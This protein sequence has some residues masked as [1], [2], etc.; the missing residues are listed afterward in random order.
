MQPAKHNEY[1]TTED[2]QDG[3]NGWWSFRTH[4]NRHGSRLRETGG[5]GALANP[6][7]LN[8]CLSLPA[9]KQAAIFWLFFSSQHKLR[10]LP[11]PE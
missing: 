2:K 9:F 7:S 5:L 10:T 8:L 1:C 11:S 3:G 6:F 4:W